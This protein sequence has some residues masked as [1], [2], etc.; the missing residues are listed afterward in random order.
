MPSNNYSDLSH[1]VQKESQDDNR[2][3][4]CHN[5]HGPFA[6]DVIVD[7]EPEK[8]SIYPTEKQHQALPCRSILR[9]TLVSTPTRAVPQ[10]T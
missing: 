4:N 5:Y 3:I 10:I 2:K 7:D 6:N 1:L 8:E 9:D